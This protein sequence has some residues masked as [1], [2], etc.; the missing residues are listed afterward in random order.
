MAKGKVDKS[1]INSAEKFIAEVKKH[2][3]VDAAFLFGS[4]AAG[5]NNENS[6]IDVAVVLCG[7]ENEYLE[8]LKLNKYTRGIDARIEPHPIKTE[9]YIAKKNPFI[10]EILRTG[11]RIA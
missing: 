10:N 8:L 7:I 6:D 4:C 1:V 9:D 3:N 5:T 11:I 2:E